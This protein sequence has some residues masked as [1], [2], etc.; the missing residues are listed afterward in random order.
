MVMSPLVMMS[1][2]NKHWE[3]SYRTPALLEG[4]KEEFEKKESRKEGR[5]ADWLWCRLSNHFTLFSPEEKC[6][7]YLQDGTPFRLALVILTRLEHPEG[8]AVQEDHQHADML[9][10]GGFQEL[11]KPTGLSHRWQK[12]GQ[13]TKTREVGG[14]CIS[15]S[16]ISQLETW[17]EITPIM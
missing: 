17:R 3:T 4:R 10:P 11:R 7:S 16:P 15:E 5:H 1:W 14:I 9:E 13:E 12:R 6:W 8:D 2:P